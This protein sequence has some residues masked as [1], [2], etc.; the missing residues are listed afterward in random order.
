MRGQQKGDSVRPP[1]I[2]F[3]ISPGVALRKIQIA[4]SEATAEWSGQ[5]T[6]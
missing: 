4:S 6:G 5:E 3:S 2:P 1:H